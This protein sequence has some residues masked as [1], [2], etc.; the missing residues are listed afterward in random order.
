MIEF[1]SSVALPELRRL[2]QSFGRGVLLKEEVSGVQD[3]ILSA[4]WNSRHGTHSSH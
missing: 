3:C 4:L 1:V 2:D